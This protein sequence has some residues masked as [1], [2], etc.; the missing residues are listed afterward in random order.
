MSPIT[1]KC[2]ELSKIVIS[3][4]AIQQRPIRAVPTCF[5]LTATIVGVGV[6]DASKF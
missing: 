2:A 6:V 5:V 3:Y 4:W 1:R